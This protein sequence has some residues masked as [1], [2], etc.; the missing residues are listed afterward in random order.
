VTT[1]NEILK[2]TKDV[3]DFVDAIDIVYIRV[4]LQ[5]LIKLY[6]WPDAENRFAR[7]VAMVDSATAR[8]QLAVANQKASINRLLEERTKLLGDVQR[9]ADGR[10]E[11][12]ARAGRA[13]AGDLPANGRASCPG[14]IAAAGQGPDST[15]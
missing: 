4:R 6:E 13:P 12:L 11:L 7:D 14:E 9:L 5:E 15:S 2:I 10:T 3:K 8:W 1:P